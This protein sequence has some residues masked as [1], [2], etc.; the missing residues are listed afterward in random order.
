[1]VKMI[2]HANNKMKTLSFYKLYSE[3]QAQE[4]MLMKDY[5]DRGGPLT[6]VAHLPHP[7][8]RSP[9]YHHTGESSY[10][11]PYE[12]EMHSDDE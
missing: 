10:Q 2:V 6:L 12:P 7:T 3:I 8:N 9:Q 1:M 5:M 11:S 4:S